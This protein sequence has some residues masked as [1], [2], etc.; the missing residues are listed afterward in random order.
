MKHQTLWRPDT[1]DCQIVYEWDDNEPEATRVH[2]P[3]HGVTCREHKN[4]IGDDHKKRFDIV[5]DENRRKN[6]TLG[7]M[8]E[9]IPDIRENTEKDP[10][11]PPVFKF[12]EGAEPKWS[13]DKSRNL[14]VEA[15]A[16]KDEHKKALRDLVD[17]TKV[18]IV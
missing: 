4:T 16:L 17:K 11:K 7:K 13:F 5:G 18:Q 2:T 1:C 15:P 9:T 14:V 8:L 3:V 12:K 6:L 10:N